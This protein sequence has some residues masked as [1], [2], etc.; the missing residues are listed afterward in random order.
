MDAT[1]FILGITLAL[2]VA[3]MDS[4]L[5]TLSRPELQPVPAGSSAAGI[6]MHTTPENPVSGT[7]E[8]DSGQSTS[9]EKSF[10]IK[11]PTGHFAP[12]VRIEPEGDPQEVIDTFGLSVP[13]PTIFISGGAG[14]MSDDD[15]VRTRDIIE[16]C[17]ARFAAEHN[18]TVIDGGTEAGVMQ[19]MGEARKQNQHT[20]PLIGIAPEARVTYPGHAGL[21]DDADL[22]D[23]HSHFVLVNSDEWGGE[24]GMIVNLTRTVAG[25]KCAM[26]GILINGGSI[27]E[28]DVYL[29]TGGGGN[30]AIPMMILEGS[31]RKADEISTASRTG[32][33]SSKV[34]RAIIAG[35]I[36]L[37]ALNDGPDAMYEKL[38]EH[39]FPQG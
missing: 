13:R 33:T 1:I 24:S 9:P 11:F 25:G 37:T 29:A 21:S 14:G 8:P 38:Q 22:E 18:I 30:N 17:I 23:G 27:A 34:I 20:F 3:S 15:I 35:D 6:L 10:M 28:H 2:I 5:K 7:A 36:R 31:G 16:N 19:M 39:F 32:Q 26:M 4:L 12:A